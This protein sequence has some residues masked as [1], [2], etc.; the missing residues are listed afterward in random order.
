MS[1]VKPPSGDVWNQFGTITGNTAGT[2]AAGFYSA[3]ASGV[4]DL[5]LGT[6]ASAIFGT[7]QTVTNRIYAI[8]NGSSD[9]V[10]VRFQP[11]ERGPPELAEANPK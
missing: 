10:S 5:Y 3:G 4:G 2:P 9:Q 11:S 6:N 8:N 1:I 7:Q